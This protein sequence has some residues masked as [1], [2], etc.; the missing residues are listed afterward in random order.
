MEVDFLTLSREEYVVLDG[1]FGTLLQERGLT[2]ESLP[3]EWNILHP[4]VVRDIHLQYLLAGAQV[5]TTNTFGASPIKLGLRGKE[6]LTEEVNRRGVR[7][8]REAIESFRSMDDVPSADRGEYRFVAGSV[9]PCGKLLSMELQPE[10][11][12]HS[13]ALQAQ[14]LDGEGIDLF[15]VETMM[16]L[17]EAEL[18]ARTLKKE[19]ARPVLVSMVFNRTKNGSFRTLFGDTV[20]D[21]VA[22]LTAAGADAV[23]TNCGLIQ[24]YLE[25]IRQMRELTDMPLVLYPNA[26]IPTLIHGE[27]RFNVSPG[28]MIESL[29]QSMQAGASILGGCCGTTPEYVELLARQLRHRKRTQ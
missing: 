25:V 21:T 28:E 4:E 18:T 19:T 2:P 24:D 14:V 22:R 1:A 16:D 15:I 13:I 10:E 8:V 17:N 23:G 9:G 5:L 20:E 7:L 3:E 29:E 26:G 11:L 12:M 27:T 6:H